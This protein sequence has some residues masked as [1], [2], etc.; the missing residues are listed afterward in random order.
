MFALF[1]LKTPP[2]SKS[3]ACSPFRSRQTIP[4]RMP[5]S[6]IILQSSTCCAIFFLD[7]TAD[8]PILLLSE[9]DF[10]F[11]KMT[12]LSA[13]AYSMLEVTRLSN[14]AHSW[15]IKRQWIRIFPI[16]TRTALEIVRNHFQ[17]SAESQAATS[18]GDDL[19]NPSG[20]GCQ[21]LEY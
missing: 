19:W 16:V 9:S 15:L 5:S 7:T 18:A 21:T 20:Q 6:T 2:H 4:A 13:S 10:L 14:L 11:Q 8:S 1:P 17:G 3:R 12:I